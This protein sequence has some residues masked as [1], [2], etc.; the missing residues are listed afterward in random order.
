MFQSVPHLPNL[1]NHTVVDPPDGRV[2]FSCLLELLDEVH[3][4][5]EYGNRD[6]TLMEYLDDSNQFVAMDNNVL[7]GLIF[8]VVVVSVAR[9]ICKLTVQHSITSSLPNVGLQVWMAELLLSDY[10]LHRSFIS[11]SF[12]DI[13]ALELGAG[14]GLAGIVLA[15]IAKTVFLTDYGNEILDNCSKNVRLSSSFS[16][17]NEASIHVREL[18][19]KESWPPHTETTQK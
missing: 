14:T 2:S 5:M 7:S 18:N 8:S 6:P 17:L 13:T 4:G 19:W 9:S 12:D 16:E 15:R 1:I 3:R 11:S 10:L